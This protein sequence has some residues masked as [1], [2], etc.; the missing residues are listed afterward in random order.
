VKVLGSGHR[1]PLPRLPSSGDNGTA[2]LV[3]RCALLQAKP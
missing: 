3:A 1:L 2:L